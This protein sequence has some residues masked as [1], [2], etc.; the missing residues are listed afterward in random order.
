MALQYGCCIFVALNG[1]LTD[2][3]PLK[4]RHTHFLSGTRA[5]PVVTLRYPLQSVPNG[6]LDW[7]FGEGRA[8]RLPSAKSSPQSADPI[9]HLARS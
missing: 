3:G 9:R 1:N 4:K 5:L 6:G 2:Q 8:F 7:W